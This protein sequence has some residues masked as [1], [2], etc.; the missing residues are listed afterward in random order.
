MSTLH[1]S[2]QAARWYKEELNLNE[3]D[4]IRFFARYSS[5]GGLHPGFSLGIAVEKPRHPAEQTEV[6]GIQ[7][8]MEDHDYWYLK[9]HQLHVDVVD[10][11]H[12]IEYRY[13]EVK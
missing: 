9:G 8:F 1:V 13:T 11:G 12:D 10:E 4:S 5:G 2:E 7:F 3:G 6:S